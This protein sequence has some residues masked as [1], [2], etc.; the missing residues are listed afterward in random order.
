MFVLQTSTAH[1]ADSV[2][3]LND[4]ILIHKYYTVSQN[5]PLYSWQ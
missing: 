5:K 4:V 1:N 2:H 3:S